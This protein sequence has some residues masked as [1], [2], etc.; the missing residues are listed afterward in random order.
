VGGRAADGA[1]SVCHGGQRSVSGHGLRQ[2][3]YRAGTAA[4]GTFGPDLTHLMSRATLGA[5]VAANTRENLRWWVNDPALLKPGALMPA[6]N[7]T[8]GEVDAVVAY[9]MTLK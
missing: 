1:G 9:L 3:S 7:L 4:Q 2:L 6:M 5:G 8:E